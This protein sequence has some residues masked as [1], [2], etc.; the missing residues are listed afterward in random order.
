MKLDRA[1]PVV[2]QTE[3]ILITHVGGDNAQ[4]SFRKTFT[5]IPKEFFNSRVSRGR[6]LERFAF[7][8]L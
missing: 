6:Q 5:G 8:R 3:V 1:E 4:Q 7:C 2:I